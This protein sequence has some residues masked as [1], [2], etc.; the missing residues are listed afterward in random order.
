MQM[1]AVDLWTTCVLMVFWGI[2]LLGRQKVLRLPSAYWLA[3][4]CILLAS[5][6]SAYA[7]VDPRACLVVVVKEVY[8]I[9]TLLTVAT[10]LSQVNQRWYRWAMRIWLGAAVAHGLLIIAEFLSPDL[11][12]AVAGLAGSP[13]DY[14][15]YRPSGL[16]FSPKAGNANKAAMYQLMAFV[17]LALSHLPRWLSVLCATV[18]ACSVLGTGSMGTTLAGV[19]GLMAAIAAIGL[20]GNRLVLMGK[21]LVRATVVLVVFA[22]L[23]GLVVNSTPAYR[24]HFSKIIVGRAEK[25]S[26]GRFSLWA[27]G[28]ETFRDSK[29]VVLGIGPENFRDVDVL[30]KQLH[31][32]ILAF[33]VERGVLGLLGLGLL[34]GAAMYR[35]A[36]LLHRE[37]QTSGQFG[38]ATAVFVGTLFAV[39][40]VSL[41]HQVFHAREIWLALAAQEAICAKH[42]GG[43]LFQGES[44]RTSPATATCMGAAS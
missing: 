16:F 8:L 12:R 24:D 7:A 23:I 3:I 18:L 40:V 36:W 21:I 37:I 26:G 10:L 28:V 13:P 9:V 38:V 17:P 22:I 20:F 1:D 32:E 30:E 6:A 44:W 2:F 5:L 4:W 42:V 29:I 14:E 35:A 41:T 34:F 39:L 27:R 25:S 43:L 33:S 19:S 15:H 31:N 11:F